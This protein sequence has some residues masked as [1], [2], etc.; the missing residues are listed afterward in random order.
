MQVSNT[1]P[2]ALFKRALLNL[3]AIAAVTAIF[4]LKEAEWEKRA[5]MEQADAPKLAEANARLGS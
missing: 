3:A 4:A 1:A 2:S 5:A